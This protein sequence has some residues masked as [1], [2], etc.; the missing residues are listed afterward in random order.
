MRLRHEDD[1]DWEEESVE[2]LFT[3][4]AMVA[5]VDVSPQTALMPFPEVELVGFLFIDPNSFLAKSIVKGA[6]NNTIN[7]RGG[8]KL[9]VRLREVTMSRKRG[10][11]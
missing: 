7:M 6:T 8:T 5:A 4:L 11:K 1:E 10:D 2:Y 3:G 9:R